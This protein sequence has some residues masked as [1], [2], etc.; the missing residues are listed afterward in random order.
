MQEQIIKKSNT[1][2][3]NNMKSEYGNYVYEPI[4]LRETGNAPYVQNKSLSKTVSNAS[5]KHN[6]PQTTLHK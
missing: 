1:V 6:P 5:L 3:R 2:Y 4:N